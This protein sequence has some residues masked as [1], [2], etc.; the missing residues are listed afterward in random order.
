[1]KKNGINNSENSIKKA[2]LISLRKIPKKVYFYNNN[3]NNVLNSKLKSY[4]NSFFENRDKNKN[5]IYLHYKQ[6]LLNKCNSQIFNN[7]IF[8]LLSN[9]HKNDNKHKE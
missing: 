5:L 7:Q 4:S 2:S 8:P 3:N 6:K 1:M 9:N